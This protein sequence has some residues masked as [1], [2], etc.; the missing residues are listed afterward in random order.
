MLALSKGES[1]EVDDIL[2]KFDVPDPQFSPVLLSTEVFSP[3]IACPYALVVVLPV[4]HPRHEHLLHFLRGSL[5]HVFSQEVNLLQKVM[6]RENFYKNSLLKGLYF[7]EEGEVE[8]GGGG[9]RVIARGWVTNGK[10]KTE[11]YGWKF[12]P[13][14]FVKAI[15]KSD[16]IWKQFLNRK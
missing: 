1:H 12:K 10:C 6:F 5:L 7:V 4:E 2:L 8:S 14:P 15:A 13:L 11:G 16:H 3:F 9:G